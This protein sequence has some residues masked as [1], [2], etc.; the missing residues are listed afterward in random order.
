[1]ARRQECWGCSHDGRGPRYGEC[2]IFVDPFV[3][4][5]GSLVVGLCRA[6]SPI[7]VVPPS[8]GGEGIPGDPVEVLLLTQPGAPARRGVAHNSPDAQ[9]G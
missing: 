1:M 4:S 3:M 9:L 6:F 2:S 5:V 8:A 7:I